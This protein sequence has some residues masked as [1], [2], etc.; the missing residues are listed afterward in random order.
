MKTARTAIAA[1]LL[2][3]GMSAPGQAQSEPAWTV[4]VPFNFVAGKTG[5]ETGRYTVYQF[6]RIFVVQ[7]RD[8]KAIASLM[9]TPDHSAQPAAHT[10]LIFTRQNGQYTLTSIHESGSNTQYNLPAKKQAN[11]LEASDS[12]SGPLVAEVS[13]SGS[14]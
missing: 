11:R 9:A 5:M 1:G 6:N 14:K 3:L 13:A 7:S 10:S 4:D 12:T 8:G 2:A